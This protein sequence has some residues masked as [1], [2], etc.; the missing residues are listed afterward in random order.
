MYE[1][2]LSKRVKEHGVQWADHLIGSTHSQQCYKLHHRGK[3][4]S[5]SGTL[6]SGLADGGPKNEAMLVSL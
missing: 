3:K 1:H 4:K 5:L 6:F 2:M